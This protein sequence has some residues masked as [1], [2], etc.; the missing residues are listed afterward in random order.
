MIVADFFPKLLELKNKGYSSKQIQ[1]WLEE[2]KG[3]KVGARHIRRVFQQ[4]GFP[5]KVDPENQ[6]EHHLDEGGFAPINNW[7]YGWLKGKDASVF[8]K[9]PDLIIQDEDYKEAV[10]E[11]VES[12]EKWKLPSCGK[13]NKKALRAIISDAHVGM[14]CNTEDA[15]FGFEYNEKIF[16]KHLS[17]LFNSIKEKIE[18]HGSFDVIIV[19]DLGD[20]LDG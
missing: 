1:K 17:I 6:F 19:D 12:I 2:E 13:T 15:V 7:Q 5:F 16:K 20:S 10:K 18:A 3:L 4:K 14:N 9:N 8:V 11:A